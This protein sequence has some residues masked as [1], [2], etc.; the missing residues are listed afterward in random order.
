MNII[1]PHAEFAVESVEISSI[2]VRNRFSEFDE[3]FTLGRNELNNEIKLKRYSMCAIKSSNILN[4][5]LQVKLV[6]VTYN[7]VDRALVCCQK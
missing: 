6:L 2:S 1:S 7:C 4:V 3:F 5:L